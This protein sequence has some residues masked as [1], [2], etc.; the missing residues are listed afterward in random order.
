[1]AEIHWFPGHMKK[2]LNNVEEKIKLVDVVIELLDAR[3]PKSSINENLT[4]LIQNKNILVVI[5]YKK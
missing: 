2:A 4:K 5:F 3:A 1:M